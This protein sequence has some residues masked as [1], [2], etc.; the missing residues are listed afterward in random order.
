MKNDFEPNWQTIEDRITRKMEKTKKTFEIEVTVTS[1]GEY[2]YMATYKIGDVEMD[3]LFETREEAQDF[4][5]D[6]LNSRDFAKR[7]HRVIQHGH[8]NFYKRKKKDEK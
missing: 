7:M 4:S 6:V 8:Y 1:S 5:E 2:L 3:L